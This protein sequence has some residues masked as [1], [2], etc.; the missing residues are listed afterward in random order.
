M[1]V[2]GCSPRPPCKGQLRLAIVVAA[3]FLS[4]V[5]GGSFSVNGR[6]SAADVCWE[7]KKFRVICSHL[8]PSSVIHLYAKDLDDFSSLVTSR[9][10]DMLVHICVDAQTGS[11]TLPSR[12]H[13]ANM[14]SA[15]TVTHRVEKRRMFESFIMET[16]SLPQT[17]S[18]LR[19]MESHTSTPA[20]TTETTNHSRSTTSS[21]PTSICVPEFF[22]H[23]PP[24]LISGD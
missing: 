17:H 16:C 18:I 15:T 8:N 2:T 1:R 19:T 23:L 7:G 9:G 12:P 13:C 24:I 6:K 20:T 22:T 3:G 4:F 11:E 14:G 10:R 5:I 21:L